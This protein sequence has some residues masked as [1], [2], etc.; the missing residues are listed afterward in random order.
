MK[1]RLIALLIGALI[2]MLG[3]LFFTNNCITCKKVGDRKHATIDL[4]K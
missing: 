3:H 1:W 4:D 2:A